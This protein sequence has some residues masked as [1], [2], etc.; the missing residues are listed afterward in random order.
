MRFNYF[1]ETEA[2]EVHLQYPQRLIE[3][4]LSFSLVTPMGEQHVDNYF[5]FLFLKRN[6]LIPQNERA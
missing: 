2:T 1:G 5:F 3:G 6:N 4:T